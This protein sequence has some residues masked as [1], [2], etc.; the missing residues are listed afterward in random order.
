MGSGQ[1]LRTC[2][3]RKTLPPNTSLPVMGEI[4]GVDT[5]PL[6]V[7]FHST[8]TRARWAEEFHDE[9]NGHVFDLERDGLP[10]GCTLPVTHHAMT[11]SSHTIPDRSPPGSTRTAPSA[12]HQEGGVKYAAGASSKLRGRDNVTVSTCNIR[13]QRAAGKLQELTHRNGQVQLEHPWTL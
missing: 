4:A 11:T 2:T 9:L 1:V 10:S 8:K 5:A 13:T 12:V 3:G 6:A 7:Y